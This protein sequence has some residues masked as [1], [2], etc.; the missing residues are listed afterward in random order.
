MGNQWPVYIRLQAVIDPA[1]RQG[2]GLH[3]CAQLR[4]KLL[5]LYQAAI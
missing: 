4:T 5:R 2:L 3:K 1:V